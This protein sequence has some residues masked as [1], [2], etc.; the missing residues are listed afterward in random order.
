[1]GIQ[2]LIYATSDEIL[3]QGNNTAAVYID[4][5]VALAAVIALMLTHQIFFSSH[6]PGGQ[7]FVG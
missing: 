6:R 2:L 4:L 7:V 1:M 3:P 5:L